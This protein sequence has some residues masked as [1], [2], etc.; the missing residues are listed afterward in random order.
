MALMRGNLARKNVH[1][2]GA[3][4]QFNLE[5]QSEEEEE[6]EVVEE[7][8]DEEARNADNDFRIKVTRPKNAKKIV[9]P[10]RKSVHIAQVRY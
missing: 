6:E 8:E 3:A 9:R 2:N 1:S 4:P 5:S 7:E 10:R